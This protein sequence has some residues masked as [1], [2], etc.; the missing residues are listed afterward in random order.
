MFKHIDLLVVTFKSHVFD[1]NFIQYSPVFDVIMYKFDAYHIDMCMTDSIFLTNT[2]FTSCGCVCWQED[3][4]ETA[5]GT[6]HVLIQGNKQKPAIVTYHDIGL[7]SKCSLHYFHLS[8]CS[9]Y[10]VLGPPYITLFSMIVTLDF[11]C[12]SVTYGFVCLKLL[13]LLSTT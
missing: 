9:S 7:N 8:T 10:E 2:P 6:V 5:L 4:I 13:C 1:V 3:D 12:H 11:K